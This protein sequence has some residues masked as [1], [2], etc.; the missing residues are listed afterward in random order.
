MFLVRKKI[1]AWRRSNGTMETEMEAAG[2]GPSGALRLGR[3]VE[4]I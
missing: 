4:G 2:F 3:S 1:C